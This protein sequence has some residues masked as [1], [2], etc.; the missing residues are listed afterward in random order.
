[1]YIFY[2]LRLNKSLNLRTI[3]LHIT[4]T[5][6][7]KISHPTT[8]TSNPHNNQEIFIP[9]DCRYA[10]ATPTQNTSNV[11]R[12]DIPI[13]L[14]IRNNNSPNAVDKVF[15]Y[16]VFKLITNYGTNVRQIIQTAIHYLYFLLLIFQLLMDI[17]LFLGYL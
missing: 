5:Q 13:I 4:L 1:M 7:E 16:L 14:P 9:L 10:S 12:S 15:I 3:C 17:P 2:F 11:I 8:R 6:N